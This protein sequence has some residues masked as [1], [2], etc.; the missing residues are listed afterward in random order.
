M[1]KLPEPSVCHTPAK[2]KAT[3]V[4][5]PTFCIA[6]GWDFEMRLNSGNAEKEMWV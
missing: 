4:L 2:R 1:Q 3:L 5:Q 6:E